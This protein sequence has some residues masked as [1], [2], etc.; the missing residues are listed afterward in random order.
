VRWT[1]A[2]FRG[3]AMMVSGVL[4]VFS[5]VQHFYDPVTFRSW[6]ILT[7]PKLPAKWQFVDLIFGLM[8]IG[9]GLTY[10]WSKFASR[11]IAK[12]KKKK[13]ASSKLKGP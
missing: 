1:V 7:V 10:F 3:L 8:L 11:I 9:S 2:K 5:G 4:L 6:G 12:P 13:A